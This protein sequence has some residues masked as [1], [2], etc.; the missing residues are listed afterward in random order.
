MGKVGNHSIPVGH[1]A[2]DRLRH[3]GKHQTIYSTRVG[4]T[5]RAAHVVIRGPGPVGAGMGWVCYGTYAK[6]EGL[7]ASECGGSI[8]L[9]CGSRD[10]GG[11]IGLGW[12]EKIAETLG[13]KLARTIL[14]LLLL[15]LA[16]RSLTSVLQ[17]TKY[18]TT[19]NLVRERSAASWNL[20][21]FPLSLVPN[22]YSS[23]TP[24]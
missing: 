23:H 22:L 6:R 19:R 5:D 11:W 13:T 8:G 20:L 15:P 1:V 16:S 17:G 24:D 3:C 7:G 14:V 12:V 10:V 21:L 9:C 18:D 4:P 2:G